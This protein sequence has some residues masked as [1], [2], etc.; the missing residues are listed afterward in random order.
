MKKY[1]F[2]SKSL[3]GK[4]LK[5]ANWHYKK[6]YVS[7]FKVFNFEKIILVLKVIELEKGKKNVEFTTV[8]VG[9]TLKNS[10]STL[11]KLFMSIFK[12]TESR[13]KLHEKKIFFNWSGT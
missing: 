5:I 10:K 12:K 11:L 13:A 9:K 7:M 8:W 1:I 3:G 4:P 6:P 2:G